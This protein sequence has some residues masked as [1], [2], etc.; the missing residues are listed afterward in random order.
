M[1]L[2]TSLPSGAVNSGLSAE[3]KT[4]L[5]RYV[6]IAPAVV[7]I[8]VTVG[9]PLIQI[10]FL[11]VWNKGFTSKHYIELFT[12]PTFYRV[13]WVTIKISA[14]TTLLCLLLGYPVAHLIATSPPRLSN[15]LSTFV[16][17][18]F[19]TSLLV[20]TYAWM[21]ILGQRGVLNQAFMQVGLISEPIHMMYN[22]SGVLV[23]MVHVLLPFMIFSLV[24]VMKGIDTDLVG[25]AKSL[26]ASDLR[27]FFH[28]YLPL[29][30]PGISSGCLIVFMM[31]LGYFV[32]PALLGGRQEMMLGQLIELYVSDILNWGYA[33]A[34]SVVLF[35]GVVAIFAL[36]QRVAPTSVEWRR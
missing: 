24:G 17:V 13:L 5:L 30:R 34:L 12:D 23:G 21:V 10:L 16:M 3:R 28:V 36:Y 29:S 33:S 22:L 31:S 15:L 11:S 4:E 8:A 14:L 27:A 35:V 9:A 26:G 20:R 19:W 2:S 25:A 7:W 32:T 18:A 6:L 1:V